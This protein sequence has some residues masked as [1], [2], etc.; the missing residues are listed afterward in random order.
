MPG[1]PFPY[2][3]MSV[4]NG[5]G[6][7]EYPMMVNDRSESNYKEMIDLT[8]HEIAH[9]YFPFYM[10][11]NQERYAWMDEGWAMFLPSE[12]QDKL[13]KSKNNAKAAYSTFIYNIY[14]GNSSEAI[15]M[16]PSYHIKDY[17]YYVASYYKPEIAYRI[18]QDILGKELFLKAIQTYI[19]H[20]NGK[21]PTPYDFFNTI[22]N[23][24]QKDL[25]WFWKPWFFEFGVPDL[26]IKKVS[27]KNNQYE[28]N[29]EK[30]GNLPV[31]IYIELFYD[32]D[33]KEII[34]E[35]AEVW[36]N[37]NNNFTITHK[38]KKK[39]KKLILGNKIIPDVNKKNNVYIN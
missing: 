11:I 6:G 3:R 14:A 13:S 17:E 24:S 20:W 38:P 34:K 2:P 8:S 37:G 15:L 1:I 39:I 19:K 21:Y 27:Y 5:G 10:G 29:I 16:R 31:P 26:G 30:I 7:M 23:V 35:S 32:D 9:T 33:S 12:L 36:K 22:N 4:F 28:I 18:L 25:F